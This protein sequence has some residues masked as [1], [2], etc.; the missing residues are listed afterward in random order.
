MSG[1][2]LAVEG[3]DGS[4]GTTQVALLAQWLRTRPLEVLT[5][6]EPS[7]LE[8]GRLIRAALRGQVAL[9]DGVLPYLFAADRRDHLD[10]EVL[11]AL[12]A[13]RWVISDRY[14]ASSLAYQSMAAGFEHVAELNGRFPMPDLTLFLELEPAACLARIAARGQARERFEDLAQLQQVRQGYERALRWC[15]ARGG[16]V[17]VVDGRGSVD[18]VAAAVRGAVEELG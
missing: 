18:E 3:L 2:F 14:L 13:G 16:A 10:R 17:A 5:T 7:D 9:G 11:P 15:Q 6:S 4:G 8:V 1:R 12:A